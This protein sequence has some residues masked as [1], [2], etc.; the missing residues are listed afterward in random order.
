MW[1]KAL[2]NPLVGAISCFFLQA[3]LSGPALSP[4]SLYGSQMGLFS[5]PLGVYYLTSYVPG[6]KRSREDQTH[7]PKDNLGE[8][9]VY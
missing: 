1:A 5:S 4:L 9:Q 8:D 2:F 6:E 3:D 7:V